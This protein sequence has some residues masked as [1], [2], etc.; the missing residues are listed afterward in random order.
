MWKS[1]AMTC[2]CGSIPRSQARA[3]SLWSAWGGTSSGLLYRGLVHAPIVEGKPAILL[4][5]AV[6]PLPPHLPAGSELVAALADAEPGTVLLTTDDLVHLLGLRRPQPPDVDVPVPVAVLQNGD[7]RRALVVPLSGTTATT[8]E[9]GPHRLTLALSRR[10][11]ETT[12]APDAL[13]TYAQ[14][15]TLS[16]DL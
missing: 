9:A 2:S 3:S 1:E 11:W 5:E 8:L 14:E 4:A 16:L 6:G 7:G 10:R 12:D 13:N 15:A